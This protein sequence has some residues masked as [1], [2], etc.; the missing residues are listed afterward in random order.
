MLGFL[1]IKSRGDIS[2]DKNFW[3]G[4]ALFVGTIIGVGLFGLP[5]ITLQTSLL[6]V[7][8]FF[9]VIT[10][11]MIL[12]HHFYAEIGIHSKE[13]HH[14]PGY[15]GKYLGRWAKHLALVSEGV[16]LFGAQLAYLIVGGGFLARLFNQAETPFEPIFIAVFFVVGSWLIWKGLKSV[17]ETEFIMLI[18]LVLLVILFFIFSFF[19]AQASPLAVGLGGN[20][21]LP[22]GVVVFS[23]FGL[24]A[25]PELNLLFRG[26]EKKLNR[27]LLWGIII[28]AIIYIMFVWSV[29]SI[30]G[31]TTSEESL[32]GLLPFIPVWLFKLAL[33]FG[34]LTTFTSF[35]A[36]GL[37]LKRMFFEDY[38][39][40]LSTSWFIAMGVPLLLYLIGF[41]NFLKAISISGSIG[42]TISGVIIYLIYLKVKHKT[43][44]KVIEH[45]FF[46]HT[47]FVILLMLLAVVGV[48]VSIYFQLTG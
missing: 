10:V 23:L 12:L 11:A 7:L 47:I 27:I 40:P 6:T 9:I 43:G 45:K 46:T 29:L 42:L 13:I 21:W 22:Y 39:L 41:N 36:I 2:F 32:S 35:L 24:S 14:T 28:A 15:A 30:S 26:Q 33:L 19:K 34:I 38:N 25:V 31:G 3:F 5:Y 18:M 17:I 48:L 8:I 4:L 16:G 20:P 1:K 44:Q 37:A